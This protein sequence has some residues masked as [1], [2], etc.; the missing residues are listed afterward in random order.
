MLRLPRARLE[1][2]VILRRRMLRETEAFL[3]DALSHPE[4][5][6]VI[7]AVPV[8]EVSFTRAYAHVFWSHI[9]GTS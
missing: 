4:R 9:L 6:V 2:W 8:G 1:H 7:P 3:E 5:Q